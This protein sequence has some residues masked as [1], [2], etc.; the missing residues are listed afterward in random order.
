MSV[1]DSIVIAV[2]SDAMY[3]IENMYSNLLRFLPLSLNVP[4]LSLLSTSVQAFI[5]VI[6][7]ILGFEEEVEE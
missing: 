5:I 2:V 1:G 7:C 4:L 6:H 3:V